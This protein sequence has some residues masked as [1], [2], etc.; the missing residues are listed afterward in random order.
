[1]VLCIAIGNPLRGDDGV[2]RRA[3]QLLPSTEQVRKL[4]VI[5]LMPENAPNIAAAHAV[6]FLDAD[7]SATEVKLETLG[8][9]PRYSAPLTHSVNPFELLEMARQLY[10]FTGEAIFCHIPA[11]KFDPAEE[12]TRE[13]EEAAGSAARLIGERLSQM[14]APSGS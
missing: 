12:L 5:Q 11:S 13:A 6:I 3:L 2:A 9:A 4:E 10:G 8:K 7:A 14:A 1:L